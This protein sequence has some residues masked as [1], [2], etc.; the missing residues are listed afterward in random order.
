MAPS[1]HCLPAHGSRRTA[2]LT[3]T[4]MPTDHDRGLDPKLTLQSRT[5]DPLLLGPLCEAD[6]PRLEHVFLATWCLRDSSR[7]L[8]LALFLARASSVLGANRTPL[9][10]HGRLFGVILSNSPGTPNARTP[11]GTS[12][13]ES[14]L[15]TRYNPRRLLAFCLSRPGL[16]CI[17][18]TVVLVMVRVVLGLSVRTP[19]GRSVGR[20]H[21]VFSRLQKCAGAPGRCDGRPRPRC[22][23]RR[24]LLRQRCS[25]GETGMWTRIG[26]PVRGE[27]HPELRRGRWFSLSVSTLFAASRWG[28]IDLVSFYRGLY[29]GAP[30]GWYFPRCVPYLTTALEGTSRCRTT[31]HACRGTSL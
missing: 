17:C 16:C 23:R 21:G 6:I 31:P 2:S 18:S 29:L 30:R 25:S 7:G 1:C 13:E 11:L 15:G 12:R 20:P 22:G 3:G 27:P 10:N 5:R 28:L 19:S 9:E 8:G 4:P 26:G 24:W 14:P